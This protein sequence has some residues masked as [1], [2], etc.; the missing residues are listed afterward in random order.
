MPKSSVDLHI[1]SILLLATIYTFCQYDLY[2]VMAIC[3]GATHYHHPLSGPDHMAKQCLLT[4]GTVLYQ[5]LIYRAACLSFTA[6]YAAL[7]KP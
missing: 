5:F 2:S 3:T 6:V 4:P 7:Q 1:I